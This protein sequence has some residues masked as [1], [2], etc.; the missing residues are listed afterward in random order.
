M[1]EQP[2]GTQLASIEA[3]Y[4]RFGSLVFRRARRLLRD[5]QAALDATQE[6]FVRAMQAKLELDSSDPERSA[7][8]WFYRITT[9]HCLNR[10][11]DE[12]RRHLWE[13]ARADLVPENTLPELSAALLLRS[14]PDDLK[15]LAVYAYLDGMSQEEIAALL[16]TSQRTISTRLKELR[17]RLRE[18][19]DE[20]AAVA[21]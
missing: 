10:L 3:L 6:V 20:R 19:L 18:A 16:G 14:L 13:G 8:G 2:P 7:V 17:A 5:E 9:N 12:K 15:A 4:R 11:R 21:S 1:T